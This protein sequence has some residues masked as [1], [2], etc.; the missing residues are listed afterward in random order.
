MYAGGVGGPHPAAD[1]PFQRPATRV[2]EA[3][4]DIEV[5]LRVLFGKRGDPAEA[6]DRRQ[7][8]LS[9]RAEP[10][11]SL[12]A[13]PPIPPARSMRKE[14]RAAGGRLLWKILAGGRPAGEDLLLEQREVPGVGEVPDGTT[15]PGRRRSPRHGPVGAWRGGGCF[16]RG[17]AGDPGGASSA[18]RLSAGA[19]RPAGEPGARSGRGAARLAAPGCGRRRLCPAPV[20]RRAAR[21][22]AA[23]AARR[24]GGVG[25]R[26]AEDPRF[27]GRGGGAGFGLTGGAALAAGPRPAPD[28]SPGAPAGRLRDR[29]GLWDAPE[30]SFRVAESSRNEM[31]KAAC[32]ASD[33]DKARPTAHPRGCAWRA[34]CLSARFPGPGPGRGS[35]ARRGC[36]CRRA[37]PPASRGSR[38]RPPRGGP[39]AAPR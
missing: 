37:A 21:A 18:G 20:S 26:A 38:A 3:D 31:M 5:L 19:A 29:Q 30:I 27:G 24:W 11:L 13:M 2:L 33:N 15:A 32:A 8:R 28:R 9:K 7:R 36:R 23:G 39:A 10:E 14:T 4:D 1:G 35:A 6:L 17:Q 16:R 22:G 34:R 25:R 12:R